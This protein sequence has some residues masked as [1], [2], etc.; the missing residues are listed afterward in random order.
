MIHALPLNRHF[1]DGDGGATLRLAAGRRVLVHRSRC[2]RAVIALTSL[3]LLRGDALLGWQLGVCGRVGS[4]ASVARGDAARVSLGHG[5][6]SLLGRAFSK[7][8]NVF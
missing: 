4:G 2:G 7:C 3:P 5:D 6:A 1:L 8:H